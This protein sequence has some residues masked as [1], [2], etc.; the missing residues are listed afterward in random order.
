MEVNIVAT[1][2]IRLNRPSAAVM[3]P[4]VKLLWPFVIIRPHHS[5]RLMQP[6]LTDGVAWSVG[7]LVWH[8]LEPCKNGWTVQDAVW[9]LDSCGLKEPYVIDGGPDPRTWRGNFEGKKGP[10]QDMSSNWYTQLTEGRIGV[11]Q[12]STGVYKMGCILAQPG[13]YNWTVRVRWRCGL[14]STYF[15]LLLYYQKLFINMLPN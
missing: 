2:R 6:I 11:V 14:M 5:T 9:D 1:W 8:D 13:E 15:D 7:R 3:R 4:F 12:M 10:A